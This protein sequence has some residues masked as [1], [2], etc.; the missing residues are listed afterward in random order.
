MLSIATWN[1]RGV[2]YNSAHLEKLTETCDVLTLTEHWLTEH[3]RAY[4]DIMRDTHDCAVTLKSAQTSRRG[5]GGVAILVKKTLSHTVYLHETSSERHCAVTIQREHCA[6]LSVVCAHLPS[7]GQPHHVYED[8]VQCMFDTVDELCETSVT[9]LCG[10]MNT[11]IYNKPNSRRSLLLDTYL[12]DRN[13]ISTY[14][15]MDNIPY[16]WRNKTHT[17]CSTV[18]CVFVPE[19][20]QSSLLTTVTDYSI[21]FEVSDHYPVTATFMS[22]SFLTGPKTWRCGALKWNKSSSSD[23]QLYESEVKSQLGHVYPD[24]SSVTEDLLENYVDAITTCLHSAAELTIPRGEYRSY[25]KP[26]W[27]GCNLDFYHYQMRQAKRK[28]VSSGKVRDKNDSH[29]KVYKDT[30]R[31]FRQHMRKAER[32]WNR[33][34]YVEINAASEVDIGEFYRTVKKQRRKDSSSVQCSIKYQD[35]CASTPEGVCELWSDYY[36]DLL[37]PYE[38]DTFDADHAE[39]VDSAVLDIEKLDIPW[40][41]PIV[42]D[43]ISDANVQNVVNSLKLKKAPGPDLLTNE[44]LRYGGCCLYGHIAHLFNAMI[45]LCYIP[46]SMRLGTILPIYK[47]GNKDKANP[48]SYR[49]ITLTSTLSKLFEKLLLERIESYVNTVNPDFPHKLQSGFRRG[50]GATTAV[51][52]LKETISHYVERDSNVYACF[53]DNEKAFDRIWHNGL[54]YKL[55]NIGVTGRAWHLIKHSYKE[56]SACV[57][58]NGHTS[59]SFP[60]R[61]GVG[62]GRVLSAWMFLLYINDLISSLDN[63]KRGAVIGDLHVPTVV[64]ADDTTLIST[65][66]SG[67]QASLNVV[68]EYACQWRLCYNPTKSCVLVFKGSSKGIPEPAFKLNESD[69]PVKT[70][71]IYAGSL[72]HTVRE[73]ERTN[74]ACCAARKT[75]YSLKDIGLR[76]GGLN[77]AVCAKVWQRV[78][79]ASSLYACELWT[80]ISKS[81]LLDLERLQRR[82]ARLVQG[83]HVR[84]PSVC[85]IQTL[86]LFSMEG[87]IDKCKLCYIGRLCRDKSSHMVKQ[88]LYFRF[89]QYI[90]GVINNTSVIH[91]LISTCVKYKLYH[92]VLTFIETNAFPAKS[93]WNSVCI[94]AVRDRES[95]VWREQLENHSAD[96]SRFC[97]VHDSIHSH[98]LWNMCLLFDMYSKPVYALVKLGVLPLSRAMCLMCNAED[99]DI[100]KHQ[101]LYCS[102]LCKERNKMF[103]E[104]FDVLPIDTYMQI[105]EC[106]DETRIITLLGGIT[107]PIEAID[108]ESWAELIKIVSRNVSSWNLQCI[109]YL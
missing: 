75:M 1:I 61:Q 69:V 21:Q 9:V 44:H 94:S 12:K 4:M 13:M 48:A 62:Q 63:L 8:A 97:A 102:K 57:M 80:N 67:L 38:S 31:I 74:R 3:T 88:L 55:F 37:S 103:E 87:Y 72:I 100:V 78:I 81:E 82:F 6:D 104:L 19:M 91:D 7:S 45:K 33:E 11:D 56:A 14:E 25:L 34:K 24:T 58:Y 109:L 36:R 85:T 46:K 42:E 93:E 23:L 5:E 106:T 68:H 28:W 59:C 41:D 99:S 30:K 95:C 90:S 98:R 43:G 32:V 52:I 51:H 39:Y 50:H 65:T 54:L 26:Y 66:H 70:S 77:P 40:C 49:G 64:L 47:G 18:D 73:S 108:I 84:S 15:H 27:K 10:D 76:A 101:L 92:Y 96:M 17:Q 22:D 89:G 107:E 86:G 105:E 71:T 53:L 60:I 83:F 35:N 79:L 20:I 16:T 29:Y 2:L